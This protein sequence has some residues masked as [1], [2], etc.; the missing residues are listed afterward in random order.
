MVLIDG[1]VGG[2][3]V[4]LWNLDTGGVAVW[5]CIG[6]GVAMVRAGIQGALC[7]G[8]TFSTAGRMSACEHMIGVGLYV[9]RAEGAVKG[10]CAGPSDFFPFCSLLRE[11]RDCLRSRKG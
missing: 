7:R 4:R 5:V 10:V 2:C 3:F 8:S 6:I 11:H 1:C 9:H